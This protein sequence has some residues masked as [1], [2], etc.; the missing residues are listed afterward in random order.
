MPSFAEVSARRRWQQSPVTGKSTKET[1]KTI[2][3]GKPGR[4]G[5]PVV[6]TLVCS[7][8]FARETAGAA[9]TRLSLLPP[10]R[11]MT[12]TARAHVCRER[13]DACLVSCL[14]FE[15]EIWAAC[16]RSDAEPIPL[17]FDRKPA[18]AYSRTII[19]CFSVLKSQ[20]L[21]MLKVA[22]TRAGNRNLKT[23]RL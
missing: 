20:F 23:S 6:T 4:S 14:K 5:E 11:G 10:F 13:A 15:S 19:P 9:G 16:A 8:H 7:Y 2:A 1:V 21:D 3:R 18:T 12:F 17:T 22:W